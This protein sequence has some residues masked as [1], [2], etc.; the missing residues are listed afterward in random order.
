MTRYCRFSN[1]PSCAPHGH[2]CSCYADGYNGREEP[3]P[4][5]LS[6]DQ[7]FFLAAAHSAPLEIRRR[8]AW[9]YGRTPAMESLIRAE[10]IKIITAR[11]KPLVTQ[12]EST[13]RGLTLL[14]AMRSLPMPVATTEWKMP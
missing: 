6:A 14:M 8:I 10:L 7:I 3:V 11:E 4:Q 12:I 5:H 1:P 9:D 2:S 13:P